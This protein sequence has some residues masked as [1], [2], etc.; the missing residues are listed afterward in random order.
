MC[1]HIFA[2]EV[3]DASSALQLCSSV[4]PLLFYQPYCFLCF[5]YT[6][7]VEAEKRQSNFGISLLFIQQ[8]LSSPPPSSTS[9]AVFQLSSLAV[10]LVTGYMYRE[11]EIQTNQ[12]TGESLGDVRPH[13]Q[14]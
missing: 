3:D 14:N 13:W 12:C 7:A 11:S 1:G 10:W 9:S 4:A 2:E 8:P 5:N 6:L